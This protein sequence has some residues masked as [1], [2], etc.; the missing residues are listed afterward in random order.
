MEYSD[1]L[2]LDAMSRKER[3]RIAAVQTILSDLAP[4]HIQGAV[5]APNGADAPVA[6]HGWRATELDMRTP[7][8]QLSYE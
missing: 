3:L 6:E 2:N 8:S 4:Q 5:E 1:H 7:H